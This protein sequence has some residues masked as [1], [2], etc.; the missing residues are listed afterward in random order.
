MFVQLNFYSVGISLNYAGLTS[1]IEL[2][3]SKIIQ[4]NW[5]L[6]MTSIKILKINLI[7]VQLC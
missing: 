2:S 5:S 7:L 4:K 3:A 6:S 1:I